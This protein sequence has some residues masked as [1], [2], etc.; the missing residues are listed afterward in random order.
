MTLSSKKEV[1][2]M[3]HPS[4]RQDPFTSFRRLYGTISETFY[5]KAAFVFMVCLILLLF[6]EQIVQFFFYSFWYLIG[7]SLLGTAVIFFAFFY[8]GSRLFRPLPR[9]SVKGHLHE[10]ALVCFL[11]WILLSTLFSQNPQYCFLGNDYRVE[12][13]ST[14]LIYAGFYLCAR[15]IRSP[16]LQRKLLWLFALVGTFLAVMTLLQSFPFFLGLM[17][18]CGLSL[19]YLPTANMDSIY[20]HPNHFAYLLA[21][22]IMA[23]AGIC[24]TEVQTGRKLAAYS[25]YALCL[26]TL[27]RNNTLGCW[28]ACLLGLIFLFCVMH[29][30]KNIKWHSFLPL[31]VIFLILTFCSE[32]LHFC[33]VNFTN[34]LTGELLYTGI[35]SELLKALSDTQNLSVHSENTVRVK[36]WIQSLGYILQRPIFGFGPDG[37]GVTVFCGVDR[38]HNEYIQYFVYFGIPG[39]SLYLTALFSL[40][41]RCIQKLKSLSP[42]AL[43]LGGMVFAYCVSAFVGNSMYYSTAY[44][45]CFL[46]LLAGECNRSV[47]ASA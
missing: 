21:M 34:N 44:F 17:E 22:V 47:S 25:M 31:T 20:S 46:G 11:L 30:G 18:R 38:P 19:E 24:L 8:G 45:V 40:L 14:Y 15:L 26:F 28:L 39:G 35:L 9:I 6:M 1:T 13:L 23:L 33:I 41:T 37:S 32:L 36:M 3:E 2:N 5:E 29:F 43:V 16:G 12:G 27:I 4:N 7:F 10:A 42:T